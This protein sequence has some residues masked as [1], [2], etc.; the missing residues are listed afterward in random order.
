MQRINE[1]KFLFPL[2]SLSNIK[3]TNYFNY[4][5]RFDDAFSRNNLRRLKDWAYVIN[6]DGKKVYKQIGFHY[7]LTEIQVYGLFLLQVTK[8]YKKC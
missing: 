3:T 8:F 6:L 7:L 1:Y 5:P 4:E 2:H